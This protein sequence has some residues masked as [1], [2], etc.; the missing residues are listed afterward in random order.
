MIIDTPF[1][2]SGKIAALK[3]AGVG[4][5]VRYYNFSNS[6]KLPDS[7][8]IP[9]GPEQDRRLFGSEGDRGG[10]AGFPLCA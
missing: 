5:V 4:T 10:D 8:H 2:T 7:G 1:N 3:A 9:A 6:S